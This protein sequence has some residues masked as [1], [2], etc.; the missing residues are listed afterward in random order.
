MKKRV[1]GK[2]EILL[3]NSMGKTFRVRAIFTDTDAANE[4]MER[5]SDTGCIA[6]FS[7]YIFVADLYQYR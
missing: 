6:E 2:D 5:N 3:L 1:L 4:Y 7:P